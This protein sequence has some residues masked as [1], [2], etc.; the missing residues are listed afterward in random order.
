MS[1]RYETHVHTSEGCHCSHIAGADIARFYK[2]L[3]YAGIFITDHF[4]NNLSNKV[5]Q[6]L[7]WQERIAGFERGYLAAKAEGDIIGLDVFMAWEYTWPGGNDFLIYGLDRDWLL[8]NPDQL[9][10]S[11]RDYLKRVRADGGLV[12]HAH[13]F[14]RADYID[15]IKLAPDVT[16]CVEVFNACRSAEENRAAKWYADFYGKIAVAG[17]DNHTG[18]RKCLAGVSFEERITH[19]HHFVRA[20]RDNRHRIFVDH[21]VVIR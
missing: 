17:T 11:P 5:P 21:D 2:L 16:D 12:V 8:A 13:P 15:C 9:T 4:F 7:P 20:I 14:R 18:A 3:G 19:I 1:F 10:W 6:D